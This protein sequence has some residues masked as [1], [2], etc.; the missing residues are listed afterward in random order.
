MDI[1][2]IS[3][4]IHAAYDYFFLPMDNLVAEILWKL[5]EV[6]RVKK[7]KA[8]FEELLALEELQTKALLRL[9]KAKLLIQTIAS[10]QEISKE[11]LNSSAIKNYKTNKLES[12]QTEFKSQNITLIENEYDVERYTSKKAAKKEPKKATFLVTY[13]LWQEKNSI[14]DIANIR[15][16]TKQTIYNHLA[17]LIE[18]KAITVQE[19]LPEDKIM[20][21]TKAFEGYTE[22]S[23]NPLKEKYGDTFTWDD[24]KIFKASLTTSV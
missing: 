6:K 24:L 22:A 10:G 9:M 4:R 21:L 11:N 5:E 16:L 15:K 12:I 17:K 3:E 13:E 8:Y 23:L 7:A 20:A 1:G 19:V 14:S 18:I 2:Y